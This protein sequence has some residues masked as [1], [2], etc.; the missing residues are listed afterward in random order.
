VKATDVQAPWACAA[1]WS[2]VE[3]L[4]ARSGRLWRGRC[5]RQQPTPTC[6]SRQRW[7][8]LW[9]T[10]GWIWDPRTH[11][12]RPTSIASI[13]HARRGPR[14]QHGL[15]PTPRRNRHIV[16]SLDGDTAAIAGTHASRW[17]HQRWALLRHMPLARITPCETAASHSMATGRVFV[18][19]PAW[20]SGAQRR[21]RCET[22]K[23]QCKRL[24]Q[25]EASV[26]DKNA[27]I[28]P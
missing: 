25:T 18:M 21:W 3:V 4:E 28:R 24:D 20:H 7:G 27:T 5:I 16:D 10:H 9:R 6:F 13:W 8:L 17:C 12:R 15:H 14:P 26:A 19:T 23:T 2:P 1:S 11:R 22:S